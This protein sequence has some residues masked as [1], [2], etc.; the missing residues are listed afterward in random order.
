MKQALLLLLILALM[1]I[2]CS[3]KADNS[4][5]SL[6]ISGTSFKTVKIGSQTWT[7]ENYNGSGGVSYNNDPS[8]DAMY[9]KLYTYDEAAAIKLPSGWRLPT[10]SDFETLLVTAGAKSNNGYYTVSDTSALKLMSKT[11]WIYTNGSNTTGFNAVASGMWSTNF[12]NLGNLTNLLSSSI[13]PDAEHISL[14]ILQTQY[15]T[16]IDL[17]SVIPA[18]SDRGSIR[19]VKD[20]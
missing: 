17:N 16:L 11:T 5:I 10:R 3:K 7:S 9:G 1:Q 2:G 8:N 13:F 15:L 6:T 19:F 20:N 12:R 4:T 14:E 18:A